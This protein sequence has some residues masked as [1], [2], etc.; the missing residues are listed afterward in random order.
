MKICIAL[1]LLLAM[2]ALA[3][4]QPKVY[5]TA[6]SKGSNWN[7]HRDQSIELTKDFQKQCQEV[8]IT[9]LPEKADYTITLNHI[10]HGFVRDNQLEVSNK[11]GDVLETREK[12][13]I[14]NNVKNA[15]ELILSD[16]RKGSHG[17]AAESEPPEERPI[18]A[19]TPAEGATSAPP[20][21]STAKLQVV[22]TPPG[23]DI[24]VDGSFVGNTP[25]DVQIA[26]GAHTIVVKKSGFKN[27]ERTLKSSAGSNVHL[28]AELEKADASGTNPSQPPTES[29]K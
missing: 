16:W 19:A 13:S 10:E 18:P 8:R 24:E 25:S 22:S 23:A 28:S 5:L 17:R 14:K 29:H 6:A 27:W 2:A 4:D 15:C 20:V 7:A 12:G 1:Y 11:E 3:Q 9:T 26:E 21:S